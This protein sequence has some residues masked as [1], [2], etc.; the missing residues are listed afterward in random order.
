MLQRRGLCLACGLLPA[1]EQNH[2]RAQMQPRVGYQQ[3]LADARFT[4]PSHPDVH[5][6][7]LP[8]TAPMSSIAT[9]TWMPCHQHE[10]RGLTIGA[11]RVSWRLR[12]VHSVAVCRAS[13]G[14]LY[15]GG[16]PSVMDAMGGHMPVPMVRMMMRLWVQPGMVHAQGRMPGR[17]ALGQLLAH[18]APT[19]QAR[20]QGHFCRPRQTRCG[21]CRQ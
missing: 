6:T 3:A 12:L 9:V 2:M 20:W 5:S 10:P 14:R 18:A 8:A 1:S 17:I 13:H 19:P 21:L 16:A 15:G 7:C 4:P 11:V